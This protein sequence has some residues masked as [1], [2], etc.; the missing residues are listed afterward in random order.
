MD[1]TSLLTQSPFIAIIF[2]LIYDRQRLIKGLEK[3]DV[4][5]EELWNY[6]IKYMQFYGA[7]QAGLDIIRILLQGLSDADFNYVM[8][9]QVIT[10]DD[11]LKAIRDGKVNLNITEK[12]LRVF[13]G[14]RR[15]NF[16]KKLNEAIHLMKRIQTHYQDYPT[17]PQ[18]LGE[19]KKGVLT[20]INEAGTRFQE[21]R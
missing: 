12:T 8:K 5:Q 19:W 7:K 3:E 9:Y 16:L 10:E 17:S 18:G 2:G 15:L 21:D 6:N 14:L 1:W 20:L 13:R 11:L 4:R